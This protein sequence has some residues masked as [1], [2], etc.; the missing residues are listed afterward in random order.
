MEINTTDGDFLDVDTPLPG[1]NYVCLSFISPEKVLK[2][3]ERFFTKKFIKSYTS[4]PEFVKGET[5][6][7][8]D[9]KYEDFVSLHSAKLEEE[10]HKE[11][12]FQTSVRGLKVR[13]VYDTYAEAEKRAKSLQQ[14]D[15]SFH[16]FIAQVG[17]WLPWDPSAD[18]IQN[19]EYLEKEL[20]ELMKNYKNNQM[21]RDIFY[22]KQVDEHKRTAA[23]EVKR[24]KEQI[25]NENSTM[26][27]FKEE[28]QD[29][30]MEESKT[31]E[32]PS[33]ISEV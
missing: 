2:Q 5:V 23:E 7:N 15:R 14:L 12:E 17:Y 31:Y 8:L 20:N 10:F 26:P 33:P 1:Q 21:Q 29:S 30:G 22:A 18:N 4:S 27:T 6:E 11:C 9:E 32:P 25:K 28:T 13:G 19:Q 24:Q 3:K 16:V